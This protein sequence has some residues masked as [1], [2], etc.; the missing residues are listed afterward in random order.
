[1]YTLSRIASNFVKQNLSELQEKI[2]KPAAI[3]EDFNILLLITDRSRKDISNDAEY[4]NDMINTLDLIN[5]YG[6]TPLPNIHF[7][8]HIKNFQKF[9]IC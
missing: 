9:T 4:S 7:K 8:V 3:T 6:S 5:K 2:D 1:M